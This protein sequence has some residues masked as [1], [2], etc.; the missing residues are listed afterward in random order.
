M[1]HDPAVIFDALRSRDQATA[2]LARLATAL[3]ESA[4]H[5]AHHRE[6]RWIEEADEIVREASAHLDPLI[7]ASERLP[8]RESE[9]P[10]F[11]RGPQ[12]AWVDA[13]ERLYSGIAYHLGPRAPVLE[14][15]FPHS[16]FATLRKPKHDA[17]RSYWETFSKRQL[18]SYVQ[19]IFAEPETDFVAPLIA[20]AA[21]AMVAWE[22]TLT[23][24][25]LDEDDA[26]GL[27]DRLLRAMERLVRAQRQ[28]KHLLEAATLGL[29]EAV[30]PA[31]SPHFDGRANEAALSVGEST[32]AE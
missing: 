20:Q 25:S 5:P 23:G 31:A 1:S 27:R 6:R 30:K 12:E 18:G 15:L 16:K 22:D 28:A 8:E 9:R 11:A 4:A 19:R 10:A 2:L 17:V 14:A 21:A 32:A 24:P 3:E 7:A 29:P 26:A 13:L